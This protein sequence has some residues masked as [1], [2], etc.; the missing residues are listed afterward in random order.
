MSLSRWMY[1]FENYKEWKSL[2]ISPF[3]WL[4][5]NK[6]KFDVCFRVRNIQIIHCYVCQC[7]KEYDLIV[8]NAFISNCTQFTPSPICI[9][10]Y[11]FLC[12]FHSIMLTTNS[13]FFWKWET[14]RY[15]TFAYNILKLIHFN[16]IHFA[17][18]KGSH[19]EIDGD[20]LFIFHLN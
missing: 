12:T 3:H 10:S 16:F 13:L 17:S 6:W 20:L 8:S 14:F 11:R 5:M 1:S 19:V 4:K 9:D 7:S 15:K 18:L 2:K